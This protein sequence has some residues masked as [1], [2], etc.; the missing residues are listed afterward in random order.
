MSYTTITDNYS[1][2]DFKDADPEPTCANCEKEARLNDRDLC[3]DCDLLFCVVC[4]EETD[5]YPYCGVQCEMDDLLAK[6]GAA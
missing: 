3:D 2:K 4:Q 5:G 6:G 1:R